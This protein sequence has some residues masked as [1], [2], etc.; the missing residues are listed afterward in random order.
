MRSENRLIAFDLD[1]TL[2][3]SAPDLAHAVDYALEQAGFARAGVALTRDWIGGGVEKLVQRALQHTLSAEPSPDL[4][5]SAFA[6]FSNYYIENLFVDS[7]LY[8]GR[9]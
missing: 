6:D 8:P 9:C 1:G 2:V 5:D 4:F 7:R 3:D